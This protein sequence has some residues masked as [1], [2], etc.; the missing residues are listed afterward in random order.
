M[1]RAAN[2]TVPPSCHHHNGIRIAR[3]PRPR[4]TDTST[5]ENEPSEY[6]WATTEPPHTTA[7]VT[8]AAYAANSAGLTEGAAV[9]EET[10]E[11]FKRVSKLPACARGRCVPNTSRR[12]ERRSG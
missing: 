2:L 11:R 6:F 8:S 4:A 10:S 5:A 3:A 12:R 7:V 1:S 9:S